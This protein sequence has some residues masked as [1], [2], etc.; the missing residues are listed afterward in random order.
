MDGIDTLPPAQHIPIPCGCTQVKVIIPIPTDKRIIALI[1]DQEIVTILPIKRVVAFAAFKHIRPSAPRND[2]IPGTGNHLVVE[3]A[4]GH[5]VR[6]ST[7]H[8]MRVLTFCCQRGDRCIAGDKRGQFFPNRVEIL[9]LACSRQATQIDCDPGFKAVNPANQ[10]FNRGPA[11][12]DQ[13]STQ[14]VHGK[15]IFA[16]AAQINLCTDIFVQLCVL[17][18]IQQVVTGPAI[19]RVVQAIRA[20]TM[21]EVATIV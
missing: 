3:H 16:F 14:T 21:P 5:D 6:T 13:V 2:V 20:T 12:K 7:K 11:V 10:N 18:R 19:Q 1:P 8:R 15:R 9:F 4:A 17:A